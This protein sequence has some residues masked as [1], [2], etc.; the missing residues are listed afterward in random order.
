MFLGHFP[1][2][3]SVLTFEL[4]ALGRLLMYPFMATLVFGIA[5][6]LWHRSRYNL[7]KGAFY[8]VVL[9]G[10]GLVFAYPTNPAVFAMAQATAHGIRILIMSLV[11]MAAG[12]AG[13]LLTEAEL[14]Q[15]ILNRQVP[16]ARAAA[17]VVTSL[18]LLA[19]ALFVSKGGDVSA[20][21]DAHLET[22]LTLRWAAGFA[23]AALY[24]H[25]IVDAGAFRLSEKPQR[26][27][28]RGRLGFL[29][30]AGTRS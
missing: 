22:T 5:N 4:T 16:L 13:R 14:G 3:P 8:V 2:M 10:F 24:A 25:F 28:V 23:I 9:G 15:P 30:G 6:V 7:V 18:V 27:W 11:T 19:W 29:L 12:T 17:S 21:L 1:E 20:W 26:E